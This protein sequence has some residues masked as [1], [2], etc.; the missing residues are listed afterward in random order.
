MGGQG[1]DF[2]MEGLSDDFDMEGLGDDFDMEELGDEYDL[3]DCTSVQVDNFDAICLAMST[4]SMMPR[5][6]HAV[7]RRMSVPDII[8]KVPPKFLRSRS[9]PPSP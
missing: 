9:R 7:D 8:T 3:R 2:D 1:D 6:N 5:L 4:I